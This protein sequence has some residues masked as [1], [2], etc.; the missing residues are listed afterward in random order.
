MKQSCMLCPKQ[1][2]LTH[3]DEFPRNLCWWHIATKRSA[4][5]HSTAQHS[6]AQHSTAQHS[7]AQ[8]STAQHSTAQHSTAQHI[9]QSSTEC[10]SAACIGA[11]PSFCLLFY[12]MQSSWSNAQLEMCAAP[13]KKSTPANNTKED[14]SGTSTCCGALLTCDAICCSAELFLIA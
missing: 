1:S 14:R 12:C 9:I 3:G 11:R 5:Q 8:H 6:T 2:T 7:T 10:R 4:A 13:I